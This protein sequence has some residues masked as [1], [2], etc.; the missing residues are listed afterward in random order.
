MAES[1]LPEIF[2]KVAL[3]VDPETVDPSTVLKK[4]GV[5]IQQRDQRLEVDGTFE[6][7]DHVFLEVSRKK[8]QIGQKQRI[9]VYEHTSASMKSASSTLVEPVEVDSVIMNYI[10]KK[11]S[12]ELDKIKQP[13][14][15]MQVNMTQVTFHSR[16]TRQGTILA[17]LAR[18]RF[19]TFYQ[20]I[21]TELQSRSYNLDATQLQSLLA[22]FPELL[23]GNG[24]G[25]TDE[26]T[27]TGRF[28]I[29]ERFEEFIKSPGKRS[30]PRQINHTVDM[31]ATASRQ[32][33]QDKSLDK[34]ETCSICLEEMVKSKTKTLEKCKHS[35]CN[36]CLKRAFEIKPVCP[37]CGVIY[38][39]LKGTQP[40]GGNM[41]ITY[42]KLSLPGYEN[43]GT[44]IINYVIPDGVQ[45]DE[46]P[47]P[48]KPYQG[49][50]RTAYLPDCTEGNKVLNLLKQAFD[51]RL[52][53]TVGYSSTTGKN[54]VVTWNDIHHKTCRYGGPTAYGYPDPYYLKR[55]QEEL[56]VKGIY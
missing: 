18:E 38:G 56:K 26:I 39:A 19:V 13:E 37:T 11:C 6:D 55:V 36:D 40:K 49:A 46:H 2:P 14:V 32:K 12:A 8:R 3:L 33:L 25:K 10:Q 52:T 4:T 28:V 31:S 47:N 29:L 5:K 23:L 35:F 51:Q 7:I 45:R 48:G 27:L 24:K 44:I 9:S 53:F 1:H 42:D 20:K 21:A 17:Q 34:E 43:Y 50:V 41:K 16:G 15:S 30:S 22:K 54:N